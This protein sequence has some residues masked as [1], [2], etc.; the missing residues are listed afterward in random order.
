MLE[1]IIGLST[2]LDFDDFDCYEIVKCIFN[3]NNTDVQI[4]QSFGKNQG[5]TVN[6]FTKKIGKDRSIIYRSL[7]KLI[8]CKICYKERRSGKKRGFVDCYYRI[9][10]KDIFKMTEEHLDRCYMKIKKIISEMEESK[11]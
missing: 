3:L 7:E 2:K 8:S 5:M 6:E 10:M 11:E 1:N 9:P 4:L